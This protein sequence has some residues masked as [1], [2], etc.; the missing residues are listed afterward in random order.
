MSSLENIYTSANEYINQMYGGNTFDMLEKWMTVGPD[1]NYKNIWTIVEGLYNGIAVVGVGLMLLFLTVKMLGDYMS[2]GPPTME[3]LMKHLA[4]FIVGYI[5][6]VHGYDILL[7]LT[8]FFDE[9]YKQYAGTITF[10][11][12]DQDVRESLLKGLFGTSDKAMVLVNA[13]KDPNTTQEAFVKATE[14]DYNTLEAMALSASLSTKLAIGQIA[15]LADAALLAVCISRGILV[16]TYTC[17]AP[18]ALPGVVEGHEIMGSSGYRFVKQYAG[19][20]LQGIMI[21]LVVW[22]SRIVQNAA[23]GSGAAKVEATMIIIAIKIAT[24]SLAQK[25]QQF[26]KDI[27]GG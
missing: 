20:L 14:D 4:R 9:L 3:T 16:V 24:I 17:M 2:Q 23:L 8:A 10:N 13:L 7:G 6:V 18:L 12:K 25:S 1:S 19:I 11:V 22:A 27:L 15:Q 21:I 5:F 26:C